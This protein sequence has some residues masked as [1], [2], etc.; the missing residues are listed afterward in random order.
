MFY[1]FN[2][3]TKELLIEADG[4]FCDNLTIRKLIAVYYQLNRDVLLNCNN[5]TP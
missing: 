3:I 2:F 5:K 1:N 4:R